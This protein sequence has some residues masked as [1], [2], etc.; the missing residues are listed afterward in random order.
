MN[1]PSVP[2]FGLETPP[3]FLQ[4]G[5]YECDENKVNPLQ[6]ALS[7]AAQRWLSAS[8]SVHCTVQLGAYHFAG[9][10]LTTTGRK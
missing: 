3:H 8:D 6:E 7:S 10:Y 1:M 4:N 5:S 9:A 2:I